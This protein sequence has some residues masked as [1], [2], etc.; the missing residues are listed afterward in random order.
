MTEEQED[1]ANKTVFMA[2]IN[3]GVDKDT[4]MKIAMEVGEIKSKTIGGQTRAFVRKFWGRILVGLSI[5]A[6]AIGAA[7]LDGVV[8]KIEDK[9][10]VSKE[11]EIH[12]TVEETEY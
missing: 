6:T 5:G 4:A 3:E 7:F 1:L 2:A 12:A 8:A 10:G 9:F 11:T